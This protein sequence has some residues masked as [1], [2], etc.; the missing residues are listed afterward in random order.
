MSAAAR[1]LVLGTGT[2]HGVPMIGC[3]CD[4]CRSSD[5]RDARLR[6]S[7]YVEVP[8]RARLLVDTTPD[9]R[10]QARARHKRHEPAQQP[11]GHRFLNPPV[12][13]KPPA[14]LNPPG[15]KSPSR[16]NPPGFLNPPGLS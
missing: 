8:G 14:F 10:Q 12:F 3:S 7:I 15:L 13:L 5:P 2:S 16:L 4:V 11:G 1:V 9:L 6:P